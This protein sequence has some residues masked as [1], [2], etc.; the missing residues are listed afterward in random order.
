MANLRETVEEL[1][2]FKLA[3]EKASD[4]IIITDQDGVIIFANDSVE[5]ITGFTKNEVLGKKAGSKELWGGQMS[6]SFYKQMWHTI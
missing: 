2:K 6:K 5:R 4:H 1:K 3:V